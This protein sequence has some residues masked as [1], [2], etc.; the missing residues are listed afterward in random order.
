MTLLASERSLLIRSKFRSVLQLRIQNRRQSEI[1]ADP[2]LK[3]S[4]PPQKPEKDRSEALRL[5]NSGAAQKLPPSGLDPETAQERTVCGGHR[6][7]RARHTQD[8]NERI[9]RPPG[10]VELKLSLES[11]SAS[12]STDVLKDDTSSSPAAKSPSFSPVPGLSGTQLKSARAQSG[13]A[14]LSATESI[15]QPTSVT[16]GESNSMA[17]AGRPNGSYMTSQNTPLLPKAARPPSPGY[18]ASLNFSHLSRPRKPRDA[19]P[20]VKKLKYHQYIPP[21]QRGGAAGGGAKQ[22]SPTAS[23]YM[24][25]ASSSVLKQQQV[26]LQLQILQNHQQLQQQLQPQQPL[27]VVTRCQSCGS[28]CASAASPSPARSPLCSSASAS[29]SSPALVSLRLPS[30]SWG[31][32]WSPAHPSPPCCHPAGAPAQAAAPARAPPVAAPASR[33]PSQMGESLMKSWQILRTE[34]R[35]ERSRPAASLTPCRSL[36]RAAAL[37]PTPSS[38]LR[39]ARPQGPRV[40]VYPCRAPHLCRARPHWGTRRSSRGRP[41]WRRRG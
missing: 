28:S 4:C 11:G 15:R 37:L 3:S 8:L 14:L 41:A 30:A 9:Q 5:N 32:A 26:F 17:T 6:P 18:S 7:K 19:K 10:P 16:L 21:D 40:P 38:W 20:K 12:E 23:Q 22:K 33:C 39:L 29:S 25:P 24:D 34:F 27:A 35:M 1:N 13:L 2:G 36:C 31:P